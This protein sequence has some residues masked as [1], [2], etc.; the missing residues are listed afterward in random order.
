MQAA[1]RTTMS[2]KDAAAG[3]LASR[4]IAVTGVSRAP[5]GHGGNIVYQR[6]NERG[7][8]SSQSTRMPMRWGAT[9]VTTTCG[10]SPAASRPS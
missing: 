1:T 3:F 5:Q 7:S 9:A 4:R 2:L 6:L 10:R 8:R